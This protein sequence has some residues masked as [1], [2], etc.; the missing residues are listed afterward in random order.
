MTPTATARWQPP[1]PPRAAT[2]SGPLAPLLAASTISGLALDVGIRGG[3][4]N[5]LMTVGLLAVIGLM[6]AQPDLS[7]HARAVVG[8][9]ALPTLFLSVWAS[10]WLAAVNLLAVGGL[11]VTAVALSHTGTLFDLSVWRLAL[12]SVHAG[13]RGLGRLP[14][15][16]RR[17]PLPRGERAGTLLRTGGAVLLALPLLAVL[18]ALLASADA[19]FAGLIV[20]DVD[21]GP[22]VS[23]VVLTALF[24]M[25]VLTV[26]LSVGVDV[27]DRDAHGPFGPSEIAVVLGLAATVL[28]LFVVSQLVA[29]TDA[30]QRLIDQAG[31]TPA[32]YARSGF[33]QL[34]W[35]ATVV[36]AYLALVRRLAT[37]EALAARKVRWLSAAVPMLA[38][39]LVGVSL[40]RMALYDQAFGLTML[41]LAVVGAI[42]WIGVVLLAM[43]AR[44]AGFAGGRRWVLGASVV[45]AFC[46]AVVAN[47]VNPEGFVVTHNVDRAS[48]GAEVDTAYLAELSDD[49]VP[50]IVAAIERIGDVDLR[51]RL[52]F[53]LRCDADRSGVA[54]W[55]LS[56]TRAATRLEATPHC[57]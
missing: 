33:F 53:A 39:G 50:A 30:G 51:R 32:E 36:V 57:A 12:R 20:P 15:L 52:Q 1:P 40:R 5:A 17:V 37:G 10:P 55:N 19:V 2:P 44:N 56:R 28:A 42:A 48:Q 11:V 43:A 54:G 34:C 49:A 41:R 24:A 45:T 14:T 31:L 26:A 18:V 8:A 22:V 16:A 6:L 4:T 29:L 7:T 27:E 38:L 47:L 25:G 23:H 46:L 21:P 9:A 13:L 3:P 35:A